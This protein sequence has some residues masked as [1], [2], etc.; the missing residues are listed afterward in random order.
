MKN[1]VKPEEWIKF[2]LG[3]EF[4]ERQEAEQKRVKKQNGMGSDRRE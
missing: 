4:R 3:S 2:K 1:E